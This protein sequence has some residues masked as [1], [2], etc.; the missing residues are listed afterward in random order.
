MTT[1]QK[2]TVT[3]IVNN[4]TNGRRYVEEEIVEVK[5]YEKIAHAKLIECTIQLYFAA[6]LHTHHRR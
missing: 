5:Y 6:I 4:G 2:Y 3:L 1:V